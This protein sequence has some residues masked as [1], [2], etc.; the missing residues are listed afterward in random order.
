MSGKHPEP[1]PANNH[2]QI[3]SK[4]AYNF[5]STKNA[6]YFKAFEKPFQ[7]LRTKFCASNSA[8]IHSRKV[9]IW[10]DKKIMVSFKLQLLYPRYP[11]D[12]K[13]SAGELV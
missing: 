8:H 12:K 5:I 3:P 9:K 2:S 1:K 6:A 10:K 4:P 13:L 11:M 7:R